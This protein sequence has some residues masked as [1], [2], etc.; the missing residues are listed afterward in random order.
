MNPDPLDIAS[1]AIKFLRLENFHCNDESQFFDAFHKAYRASEHFLAEFL[2]LEKTTCPKIYE[3]RM[4]SKS[5][6]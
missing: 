2:E 4:R 3:T 5:T 6:R 1:W